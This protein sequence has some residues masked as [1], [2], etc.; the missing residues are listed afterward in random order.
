MARRPPPVWI[1]LLG[2]IFVYGAAAV[3]LVRLLRLPSDFPAPAWLRWSVGGFLIVAGTALVCLAIRHLSLRRA[4]GTEIYAPAREST[5]I[6]TGPY[7]RVRN[8]LYLG[9]TIALVGWTLLLHSVVLVV[10]TV[11]M[12][13]H[14]VC[15]A[16]WEERE[17]LARFGDT[18][19]AYRK[20]TPLFLPK[21][22]RTR[23]R[24]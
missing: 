1:I 14:F 8:P 17:L 21:L 3:A 5:L 4:F 24:T 13:L 23:Y 16:K 9:A 6:A 20:A 11:L 2:V 15:V 19:D 10:V 7:E 12:I 22:S 18:Y